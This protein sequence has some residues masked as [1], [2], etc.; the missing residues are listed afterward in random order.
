MSVRNSKQGSNTTG[1]E[2]VDSKTRIL[3]EIKSK[4]FIFT[5]RSDLQLESS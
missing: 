4:L 3:Y 1:K 5:F 2:G